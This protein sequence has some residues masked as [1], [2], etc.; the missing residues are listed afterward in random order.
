MVKIRVLGPRTSEW[1]GTRSD[2]DFDPSCA[3]QVTFVETCYSA[4]NELE[5]N[6]FNVSLLAIEAPV[7]WNVLAETNLT[8]IKVNYGTPVPVKLML[9]LGSNVWLL[10]LVDEGVLKMVKIRITGLASSEWLGTR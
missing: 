5:R 3:F 1:I 10:G 9:E 6:A 4:G 2:N 8:G 7:T